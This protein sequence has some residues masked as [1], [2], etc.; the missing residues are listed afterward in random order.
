MIAILT[1]TPLAEVRRMTLGQV[2]R[3]VAVMPALMKFV[4]PML[5]SPE[6]PITD[7]VK[8]AHVARSLGLGKH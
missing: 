2:A 5:S 4:N 8:I 1:N 6:A 7:P 3:Y